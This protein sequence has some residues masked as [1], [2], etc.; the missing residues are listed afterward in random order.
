[1]L[2]PQVRLLVFARYI[3]LIYGWCVPATRF[4]GSGLA[5]VGQDYRFRIGQDWSGL[6]RSI[7]LKVQDWSE[8][9]AAVETSTF[10][11]V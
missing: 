6:V 10:S 1:M 11:Q 2:G 3:M 9:S 5:V 8:I 4:G 7:G